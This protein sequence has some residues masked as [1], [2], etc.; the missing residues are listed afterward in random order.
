VS[1]RRGESR[2][3]AKASLFDGGA[4]GDDKG[5]RCLGLSASQVVSGTRGFESR[6]G[7]AREFNGCSAVG[8]A[9]GLM[10]RRSGGWVMVE[11]VVVR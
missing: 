11:S 6:G 5:A 3:R 10:K 7:L 1:R 4:T 8:G 2:L 9:C